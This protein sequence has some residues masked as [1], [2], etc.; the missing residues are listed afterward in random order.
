MLPLQLTGREGLV[1]TC[2]S[3]YP[4]Q[5]PCHTSHLSNFACCTLA[6]LSSG[7]GSRHFGRSATFTT[8]VWS[9]RRDRP[10]GFISSGTVRT[11]FPQCKTHPSSSVLFTPFD[12]IFAEEE[13]D[14]RFCLVTVVRWRKHVVNVYDDHSDEM[15][16]K[17]RRQKKA[18]SRNTLYN[19]DQGT[20]LDARQ[21]REGRL[22]ERRHFNF[23]R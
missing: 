3:C 20:F 6:S 22:N 7:S 23:S 11:R 14:V 21:A 17:S 2:S 15:S 4:V 10:P 12:V 5:T 16:E 19:F 8:S 9:C 1:W 13:R 18:G